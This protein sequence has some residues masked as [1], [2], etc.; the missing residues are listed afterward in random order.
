MFE[1][2][3]HKDQAVVKAAA[4]KITSN[5]AQD[6][7]ST[8]EFIAAYGDEVADMLSKGGLIAALWDIG[9]NCTPSRVEGAQ[10]SGVKIQAV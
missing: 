5:G 4:L 7:R 3:Y 6:F 1:E 8:E 2:K 9:F 10:L